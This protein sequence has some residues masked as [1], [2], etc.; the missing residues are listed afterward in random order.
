M[1][2]IISFLSFLLFIVP[3]LLS[4]AFFTLA[5]RK[6]MGTIQRR[7]GPNTVGFGPLQPIADGVKLIIKEATIP[8]A[9]NFFVFHIAPLITIMLSLFTWV[10]IPFNHTYIIADINLSIFFFLAISSL[11]V[12]GII[13]AGWSSNSKY[14]F[15]GSLRAVA[16]M[17]SYEISLGLVIL[18]IVA[19]TGSLNFYDI[20]FFQINS[21]WFI[22]PFYPS[23][24]F[25]FIYTIS[26]NK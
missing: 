21:I 26:W 18:P 6:V 12:Y 14:A 17:I 19:I 7:K 1:K 11:A 9:A 15:L 5:E 25:F 4:I 22:I 24:F 20:I 16:Q 13:F 3:I 23:F 10:I 2:I 8:I